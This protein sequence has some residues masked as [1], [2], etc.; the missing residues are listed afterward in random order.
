MLETILGGARKSSTINPGVINAG[1]A[2]FGYYG[3]VPT[4]ITGSLLASR[5][6][7]TA[8][9]LINDST[10]WL[11]FSL[12]NKLA[13]IPKLP[14]RHSL[15]WADVYRAGCVY[16]IAGNGAFPPA[17]GGVAQNKR[18]NVNL[19]DF[20]VMLLRIKDADPTS[21]P[22]VNGSTYDLFRKCRN[23]WGSNWGVQTYSSSEL[24]FPTSLTEPAAYNFLLNTYSSNA[25]NRLNF[26]FNSLT[27]ISQISN[28]DNSVRMA[29]RPILVQ[30]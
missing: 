6:G 13:Y 10:P 17:T 12:N 5:V 24:G 7:L 29:W 26:Q 15:S 19:I 9:V 23:D 22:I 21:T 3:E 1:N 4:F 16:G 27:S 20:Y 28:T 2:A 14:I 18:V 30:V 11:K 25:N 8:G